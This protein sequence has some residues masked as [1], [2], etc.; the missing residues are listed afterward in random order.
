MF[1]AFSGMQMLDLAGPQTVF[2]LASQRLKKRGLASYEC[3]TA[4]V[5]GGLVPALEGVALHTSALVDVA[6]NETDTI[7]IPGCQDIAPSVEQS[8]ELVE[9]LRLSYGIARRTA[10]L[11]SGAFLL[12]KAGLLE[13]K[14]ATTHWS[15][16]DVLRECYPAIEVDSDAIFVQQDEIWTSA[17]VATGIDLALALIEADCGREIALEVA[18][19]L[20]VFLKRPGGQS[21]FSMLLQAQTQHSV[22]FD[23]LHLWIA[24]NLGRQTLTVEHLAERA[25]MS[26]RNFARVYK[27]KT[28]RSPAKAVEVFRLEAAQRM[29]EDSSRSM[30]QIARATG[31]GDEERMR[32]TFQRNLGI[33]PTEYRKRFT[34]EVSDA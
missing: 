1:I 32:V 9:W 27:E 18:R 6:V 14:R 21:Q 29:L 4:S 26:T 20:V 19:E 30:G 33:A 34:R 15:L 25:N 5:S 31:F 7:F 23:D 11:G 28:G 3:S 10:A 13:G 24:D 12:A 17:G 22:A 2:W 16:C 8:A